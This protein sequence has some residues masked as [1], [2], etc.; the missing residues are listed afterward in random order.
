[1]HAHGS[2]RSGFRRRLAEYAVAPARIAWINPPG[3]AHEIA[4]MQEPFGIAVHTSLEG[5][6]FRGSRCW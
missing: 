6:V 4:A 5:S 2:I 3:L 1:V